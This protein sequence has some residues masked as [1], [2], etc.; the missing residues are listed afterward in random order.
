[1][2]TWK[3]MEELKSSLSLSNRPL[4]MFWNMTSVAWLMMLPRRVSRFCDFSASRM[5]RL[6]SAA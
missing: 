6:K 5:Q 4:Q 3:Q 2:R 1:M